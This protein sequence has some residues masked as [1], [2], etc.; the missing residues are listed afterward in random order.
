MGKAARANALR[1]ERE[2]VVG[3]IAP[4]MPDVKLD[5]PVREHFA[6]FIFANALRWEAM[7][8]DEL[9][10]VAPAMAASLEPFEG[11]L[12][13]IGRDGRLGPA[14]ENL[15]AYDRW[16]RF[17]AA[18][19]DVLTER[20]VALEHSAKDQH[21]IICGAGPTLR[22]HMH[23]WCPQADQLWGVNSALPYLVKQGFRVTHGITVDQTPA[24]CEEW[25]TAPDVEYLLATTCHPHLTQ[26]LLGKG[27]RIR[28]FN[29]FVGLKH[30]PVL[31]KMPDGST[32]GMSYEDWLYSILFHG[33]V[34]CGSGLNSTTRAID[35][36]LY[37][38]AGKITVLGA[39]CALRNLVIPPE[40]MQGSPEHQRLLEAS[41]MH[42]DGGHALASGATPL[43]FGGMIDGRHWET[44][45][46]MAISAVWL[47]TMREKLEGRLVLIGDTL[48][49][50]LQGKSQEFI[51]RM[52]HL[53][54]SDNQRIPVAE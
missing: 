3:A 38:G 29:N 47:N 4:S 14:A 28:F 46:D 45:P 20:F 33:T 18:V 26:Y 5:N 44:K 7:A 13:F 6:K 30:K 23:E 15:A 9:I 35:M 48:P 36:A 41:E 52:P 49:N 2:P 50:A 31:A 12:G 54:G 17:R 24:M 42:A 34:R 37:L 39:D 10:R 1:K 51:D 19:A 11:I 40:V 25:F 27:R 16:Q 32:N 53:V 8:H 22:D 43:T 21:I